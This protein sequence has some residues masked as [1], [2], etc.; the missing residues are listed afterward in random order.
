MSI[1]PQ[2]LDTDYAHAEF[3][4]KVLEFGEAEGRYGEYHFVIVQA[5]V[6]HATLGESEIPVKI[7]VNKE[8]QTNL[9]ILGIRNLSEIIGREVKFMKFD[10]GTGDDVT[11][12]LVISQIK[13]ATEEKKK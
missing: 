6:K 2:F 1:T 11:Q 9:Y 10:R 4:A 3:W 13:P 5:P 8:S 12:I 7:A